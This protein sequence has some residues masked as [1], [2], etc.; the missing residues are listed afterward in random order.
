M[1][2]D[3]K[4]IAA[5]ATGSGGAIAVI[6]LSGDDAF[7]IA[8]RFFRPKNG[9]KPSQMRPFTISYGDFVATDGE[10]VD[11]L[12]LSKFCAPSSY[13]GEDMIEFSVHASEYIK[14]RILG[15]LV[16][17]G[18]RIA[19]PGEYT[20]RAYVNGKMD[21]VEAEAVADIIA[22]D[23]RAGHTLALT[24]MRG[25]YTAEFATL[26]DELVDLQSLLELELDF[27]EEDV[28]FAD[29]E[30]LKTLLDGI[31][32]KVVS[33]MSSY[34]G[35]S[36][37]KNG[38][39]VAII[40]APNSGKSTL[41]NSLLNEDR[42]IVSPV[43]G[44][45]RDLIE[46]T[47]LLGDVMFRFIDTAGVR[48]TDDPLEAIG[49]DRARKKAADARVVLFVVDTYEL[50][51]RTA[52][53]NG[54]S[55]CEK[56]GILSD[57]VSEMFTTELTELIVDA[58]GDVE[59][60]EDVHF[61]VLLNKSDMLT[62]KISDTMLDALTARIPERLAKMS[63]DGTGL[64]FESGVEVRPDVTVMSICAKERT[65]LGTLCRHLS[66]KFSGMV[67]TESVI[68]TS[69]RHLEQLTHTH[70]ALVST[71]RALTDNLPT[72]LVSSE[73]RTALH[74]LG[75]LTGEITTQDILSNIFG[76]FCIGK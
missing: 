39:P 4:T 57:N 66:D 61:V 54:V 2:Q 25:G 75:L 70:N 9:V 19:E 31:D 55:S 64:C 23:S 37:I 56:D 40:G 29:R 49:I 46:E 16:S 76:K 42:A 20:L 18:A 28:E 7:A 36:A 17:A 63:A 34:S 27:S 6:R 12:L 52:E 43:A 11:D 44:T 22:S 15:E 50:I 1:I 71:R 73:L 74:H 35:G 45:T 58:L 26:R 51:A 68:I 47:L 38:V 14:T 69:T 60:R 62:R 5:I 48:S 65:A 10:T 30:R 13:T 72:D 67:T 33:L 21:M 41:L 53:H 8:D 32:T 24:Q 59:L 3:G